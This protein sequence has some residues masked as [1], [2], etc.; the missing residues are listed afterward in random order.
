MLYTLRL[1]SLQNAVCFVILTCLVPVL[2]TFYIQGVLKLKQN[3]SGAKGLTSPVSSVG[4]CDFCLFE[5]RKKHLASKKF[6]TDADVKQ[7]V[8]WLQTFDKDFPSLRDKCFHATVE[9]MLKF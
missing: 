4:P 8:T 9:K 3:N 7:A 6:A 1:F 2:F 5:P